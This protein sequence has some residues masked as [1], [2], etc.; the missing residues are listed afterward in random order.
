MDS[1]R[2]G[3]D[4][5][6]FRSMMRTHF[7]QPT[8]MCSRSS[9][10]NRLPLSKSPEFL[11]L[12]TPTHQV[13]TEPVGSLMNVSVHSLLNDCFSSHSLVLCSFQQFFVSS[14]YCF[15]VINRIHDTFSLLDK[16]QFN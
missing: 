4:K 2:V 9:R 16:D 11:K 15:V 14:A 7:E 12:C 5:V 13:H 8:D 10:W 1:T 3:V 6:G